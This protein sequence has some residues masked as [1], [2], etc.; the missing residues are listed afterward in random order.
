M[1]MTLE[2]PVRWQTDRFFFSGMAVASLLAV[3]VGFAP[4]YFFRSSTLSPLSAFYQLHGLVFMSWI[5]LF[6]TQTALVA[7]DRT[8]GRTPH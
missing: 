2:R 7:S 6:I 5:L 3:V 1:T 8:R 4:T